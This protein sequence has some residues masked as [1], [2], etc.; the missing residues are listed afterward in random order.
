MHV[1]K[2]TTTLVSA[3]LLVLVFAL[4]VASLMA[5][6]AFAAARIETL[7]HTPSTTERTV[8]SGPDDPAE[9]EAF[10]DRFFEQKMAELEGGDGSL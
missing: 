9:M 6:P 10:M 1:R 3:S 2:L 8:D 7:S 4:A 5:A